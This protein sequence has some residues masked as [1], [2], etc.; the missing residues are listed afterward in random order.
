MASGKVFLHEL[1]TK[2]VHLRHGHMGIRDEHTG[3]TG[4]IQ[5]VFST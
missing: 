1:M 3:A 4:Q 5:Q 2:P